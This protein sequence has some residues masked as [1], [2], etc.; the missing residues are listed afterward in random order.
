MLATESVAEVIGG[1]TG[2]ARAFA[3]SLGAAQR[4]RATF[5]FDDETERRDWAY[6][7]RPRRGLPF[8]EM[9]HGQRDL[10]HRLIA[11]GLSRSAYAK[12]TA[13]IALERVLGELEGHVFPRDP[14]SYYVSLFGEPGDTATWGWRLDGHHVCLNYTIVAGELLSPTPVFLGANPA[15][16][17]HGDRSVLRPLGEEE[18]VAREL[19]ASLDA[20]QRR[21]A[22]LSPAA[23]PDIVTANVPVLSDGLAPGDIFQRRPAKD[24]PADQLDAL[25]FT[26]S[27]KGLPWSEMN[28]GQ[29]EMLEALVRVYIER[30]PDAVAAHEMARLGRAGLEGIHFAWAGE[31]QRRRPH[32]YRLQGPSFLAEYDNTQ[33]DANHIH[34]VWRDAANDFGEDVLR[35]HY[36][37]EHSQ[38]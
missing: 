27:P 37:R 19:L 28:T 8:G 16:V 17:R 29:R 14:G 20:E 5:S 11:S 32:Y 1:M 35:E 22:I 30:M 25:T 15:E 34:A 33:N 23:P 10:A 3:G 12:A 7:P 18:D 2:A 36:R 9:E 24:M 38:A 4:A 13:I 21:R 26:L 31:E 6:F